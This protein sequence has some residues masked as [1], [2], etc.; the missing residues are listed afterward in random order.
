MSITNTIIEKWSQEYDLYCYLSTE[1][2]S[3]YK[4]ILK[5]KIVILWGNCDY[6]GGEV[7]V[8]VY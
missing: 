5:I 8:L 3:R 7:A 4:L 2:K 6:T 1:Y